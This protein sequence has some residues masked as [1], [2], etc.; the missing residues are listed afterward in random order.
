MQYIWTLTL[1]VEYWTN[2]ATNY[3]IP[4]DC[5]IQLLLLQATYR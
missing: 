2:V 4:Q 3:Q 5:G 1:L